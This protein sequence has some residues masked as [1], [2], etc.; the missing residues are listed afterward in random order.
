MAL[1][2]GQLGECVLEC[3]VDKRWL[4]RGGSWGSVFAS[5]GWLTDGCFEGMAG[6]CVYHC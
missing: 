1:S 4:C 2:K 3:W 5:A 6:E